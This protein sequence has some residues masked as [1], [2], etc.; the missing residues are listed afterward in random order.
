MSGRNRVIPPLFLG[1]EWW[2]VWYIPNNAIVHE[3]VLSFS[4]GLGGVRTGWKS[5]PGVN[6]SYPH[7]ARDERYGKM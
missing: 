3:G 1:L 7:F 4:S 2:F 6:F 5:C